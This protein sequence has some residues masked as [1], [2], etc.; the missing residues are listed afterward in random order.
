MTALRELL[1]D[2]VRTDPARVAFIERD[3]RLSYAEV[4]SRERRLAHAL[5]GLG[6]KPGERVAF[7]ALN[8]H[9][10]FEWYL[11]CC[12][13]GF[14]GVPLNGR[15]T[16][17]EMARFLDYTAAA[18]LITDA[19][20]ASTATA[21]V[22]GAPSV[23]H[24]VGFGDD[25]TC[26]LDYEALLG[27]ADDT[28]IAGHDLSRPVLLA[29]TSGTTGTTRGAVMTEANTA[30]G[31]DIWLNDYPIGEASRLL[32]ALPLYFAAATPGRYL[33]LCVG[34][35][36]IVLP[37]FSPDGFAE[38]VAATGATHTFV[39]PA[40]IYQLLDAG[41]DPNLLASLEV[42]GV[43]GAPM[44]SARFD[45]ARTL[46]GDTMYILYGLTECAGTASVLTPRD[47]R[48]PEGARRMG[49]AG[50]P[51]PGVEIE[52]V[53]DRGLAR[54]HDGESV[55]EI[56]VAGPVVAS[57]YWGFGEETAATFVGGRLHTGDLGTIDGDGFLVVV[58]RKKDII[59][60][61]GINVASIEVEEVLRAHPDV[62]DVA[63]IGVPHE[64]W[65][66]GVHAVIV[67]AGAN[68]PSVDEL[69][70][71]CRE[72][73]APFKKP[74]SISYVEELPRNSTGKLLK[75]V[76]REQLWAPEPPDIAG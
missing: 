53:D 52:V 54:P 17:Q 26:P 36:T 51:R 75:R 3:E 6:L 59:V 5:L 43:G 70:E 27:A 62:A 49:S 40:L 8:S 15:W 47:Y 19:A 73:L 12:E 48:S 11:A 10:Y 14:I 33:G 32:L 7:L 69:G 56:V 25:H 57:G 60:S 4:Q 13:A 34:A 45:A 1:R 58:D 9:R 44:A 22:R 29:P 41:V 37:R 20:M 2:H 23:R 18:A 16:D 74:R 55:G 38:L 63:V 42:V 46:L 76:L 31:I 65:G 61:G 21:A 71:W 68:H 67:A 50:K 72:R 39:G 28:E 35:T 24:L 64:Q 30:A 66:E